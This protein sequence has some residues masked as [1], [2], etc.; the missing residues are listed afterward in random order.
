MAGGTRTRNGATRCS[1]LFTHTVSS[2]FVAARLHDD[3]R[4]AIVATSHFNL[5]IGI[6]CVILTSNS[7]TISKY[8]TSPYEICCCCCCLIGHSRD[9]AL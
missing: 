9:P 1:W 4:G 3:A 6:V 2:P 5:T 8:N 7:S